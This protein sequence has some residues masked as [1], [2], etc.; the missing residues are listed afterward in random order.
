MLNSRA[1]SSSRSSRK[2]KL[3]LMGPA[4]IAAI[5]YIDP[6]NFATNIQ[7]GASYG[8]QLLWVVVWANIMAMLIQLMSAKLGIATG[9]NLAEH[10]RDRFPRPAVWAYWVQAEIIAMAT[11]L[12]EF[13]GAAIGFKLLLGVSLLE[14]AVLTGIATFIILGLQKR[15]QK[16]LELV[17]GGLLLFVA[18]AYIVE[19]FFS[20]PKMIELGKGMLTPSLP[21]ANSVYLAA[22]VLGATIM[23]HVIY[24]HSSLTQN[25]SKVS[26]GQRYSSTK[27]DVA[28]AM[29]IAGFVNLAMM[30]T[31]AAAFH[32][33]GHKGI[34]ELEEAYL[35][36]TPLLGHAAATIFGLSLVAAGLSSTVVGTLAGQVVMQGFVKFY[37]PLWV[38]R[39][40]TMA[41]S[42]IVILA[43]MDATK[44]LVM[45]Q[46]LLSF[47]IAL[48]LLPLLAFTGNRELMGDMVNSRAMQWAGRAIV[49][50]VVSLNLYL[51]IGMLK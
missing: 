42:F 24:L 1:E 41:P 11:D 49:L 40:V 13:I 3:S 44:I 9:K 39:A 17:I 5:G 33:S 18:L 32:F 6:G 26:K 36:L 45:S 20:Q 16:P 38:R 28:V 8:Y 34:S 30:A 35:T 14:G 22:G 4:F 43:G 51:L 15:G 48:A 47:G 10:I 2:I 25:S 46:V 12:A 37:I 50:V 21:D 19:L 7:A 31:A 27:L 29:T 23:P